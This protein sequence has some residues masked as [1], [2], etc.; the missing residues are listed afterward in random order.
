MI[1][2]ETLTL[3]QDPDPVVLNGKTRRICGQL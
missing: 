1:G 2:S 3:Q